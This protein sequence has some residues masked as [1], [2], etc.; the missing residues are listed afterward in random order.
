LD[1]LLQRFW[2]L[3]EVPRRKLTTS[4][5][6][7]CE[8]I[9]E[10]THYRDESGRY[11]VQLPFKEATPDFGSSRKKA[12][13]RLKQMETCLDRS[14][15]RRQQYVGFMREYQ[16]LG[17]TELVP[18]EEQQKRHNQFYYLPY[19]AVMKESSNTTNLR[20]V[21]EANSKMTSGVSLNDKLMVGP[22]LQDDIIPLLIRFLQYAVPLLADVAKMCRQVKV[23]RKDTDFQRIVRRQDPKQSIQDYRLLTVTYGT[24]SA[25]YLATRCLQQLAYDE[26]ETFP[27][28]TTVVLQNVLWMI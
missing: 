13:Q 19:H 7:D 24:A 26:K 15:E 28:A 14:Q 16:D 11:V 5:E 23:H 17:H 9:F 27:A 10:A 18:V 8:E 22:K 1:N 12:V 20:V 25:S 4:E 3:E 2:N 6:K 21:F